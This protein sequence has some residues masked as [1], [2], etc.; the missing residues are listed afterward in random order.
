[1]TT[2]SGGLKDKVRKEQELAEHTAR[3]VERYAQRPEYV[4]FRRLKRNP[5]VYPYRFRC[6]R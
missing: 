3:K 6:S 2:L 1:M 5:H 4:A